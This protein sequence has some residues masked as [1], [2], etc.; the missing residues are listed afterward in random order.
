MPLLELLRLELLLPVPWLERFL[1]VVRSS[2][3]EDAPRAR[4]TRA[5]ACRYWAS[6]CATVWLEVLSFSTSALSWAS[7]YI[8]HHAPRAIASLGLAW[9]QPSACLKCAGVGMSGVWK[10]GPTAQALSSNAHK[11]TP[12]VW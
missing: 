5:A 11:A 8:S 10:S 7:P 3:G 12:K 1:L 4:R 6:Y 9:V 2:V